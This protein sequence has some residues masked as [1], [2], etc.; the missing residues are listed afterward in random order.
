MW[1]Y[2]FDRGDGD[3][4]RG[5]TNQWDCSVPGSLNAADPSWNA[6]AMKL[7]P[8]GAALESAS[9]ATTRRSKR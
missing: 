3:T 4:S 6:T 2:C 7:V 9:A 5:A 1:E 8:S